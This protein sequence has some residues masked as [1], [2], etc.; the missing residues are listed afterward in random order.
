VSAEEGLAVGRAGDF[1]GPSSPAEDNDIVALATEKQNF[2][3]S[4][5]VG[6]KEINSHG[7]YEKRSVFPCKL[8]GGTVDRNNRDMFKTRRV[9]P[10]FFHQSGAP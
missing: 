10:R 3:R 9:F 2:R 6:E 7:R 4:V 5:G 1:S 8:P